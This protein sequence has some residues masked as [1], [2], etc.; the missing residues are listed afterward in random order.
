MPPKAAKTKEPDVKLDEKAQAQLNE[1]SRLQQL[2][3]DRGVVSRCKRVDINSTGS[4][5]PARADGLDIVKKGNMR[6][7]RYL[8]NISARLSASTAGKLGT[9]AQLDTRN[10]T[11]YIDFPDGRLKF[12]GTLFFPKNK[13][14]TL[15]FAQKEV[16]CED[17]FESMIVFSE[18]HWIGTAEENPEELP[19]PLPSTL[20]QAEKAEIPPASQRAAPPSTQV[21]PSQEQSDVGR[22]ARSSQRAVKRKKYNE[23]N[24]SNSSADTSEEENPD[25]GEKDGAESEGGQPRDKSKKQSTLLDF[26]SQSQKQSD[27]T[28]PQSQRSG[29]QRKGD[30][31]KRA[32]RQTVVSDDADSD[33]EIIEE[34]EASGTQKRSQAPRTAKATPKELVR[35]DEEEEEDCDKHDSPDEIEEADDSDFEA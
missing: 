5:L 30:V 35:I 31:G 6:K 25:D 15:R 11:L 32:R 21:E 1:S 17:I 18:H 8:L 27:G 3:F 29:K 4:G 10:P 19:M 20:Q 33:L 34:K 9:L 22:A 7:N 23:D 16:L 13:Y 26:L 14:M 24:S 12:V 2:A 28:P